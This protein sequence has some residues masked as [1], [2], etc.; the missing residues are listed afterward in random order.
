MIISLVWP[1]P[2]TSVPL[3]I[4][5]VPSPVLLTICHPGGRPVCWES[6]KIVQLFGTLIKGLNLYATILPV[7][8]F[9]MV[10]IISNIP[11][12]DTTPAFAGFIPAAGFAWAF[13]FVTKA[14]HPKKNIANVSNFFIVS[15]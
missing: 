6:G 13:T 3:Q 14:F 2:I 4:L 1:P 5:I 10:T 7:F 8:V 12:K 15:K 9:D 11:P